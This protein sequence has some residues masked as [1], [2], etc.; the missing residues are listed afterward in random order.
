MLG[1][2]ASRTVARIRDGREFWPGTGNRESLSHALSRD[3]LLWWILSTHRRRRRTMAEQLDA[4]PSV[5]T[6]RLR[7]PAEAERWLAGL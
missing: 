1:R 7:S 5:R 4:R 3:G 6:V 2:W